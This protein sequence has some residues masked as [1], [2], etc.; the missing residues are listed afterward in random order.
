MGKI[1]RRRVRPIQFL[2]TTWSAGS[3]TLKWDDDWPPPEK[4][5]YIWALGSRGTVAL[6]I[7]EVDATSVTP[8][9]KAAIHYDLGCEVQARAAFKAA[10]SQTA[11]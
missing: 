4:G 1:V 11:Q 8:L 7:I 5:R 6:R 10:L 3:N 9:E 2:Q